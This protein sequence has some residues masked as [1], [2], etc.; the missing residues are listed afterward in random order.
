MDKGIKAEGKKESADVNTKSPRHVIAAAKNV[1]M[2]RGRA[3]ESSRAG[4]SSTLRHASAL[5]PRLSGAD[6]VDPRRRQAAV[7][8]REEV[9]T[10]P[11]RRCRDGGDQRRRARGA[12]WGRYVEEGRP[13]V[14]RRSRRWRRRGGAA[15]LGF[16]AWGRWERWC[17]GFASLG[18]NEE[19]SLSRSGS[20]GQRRGWGKWWDARTNE[21]EVEWRGEWG[22]V[23]VEE[24]LRVRGSESLEATRKTG[25][26]SEAAVSGMGATVEVVGCFSELDDPGEVFTTV[27]ECDESGAGN[28]NDNDGEGL[29]DG[30]FCLKW[31][32]GGGGALDGALKGMWCRSEAVRIEK[33][34]AGGQRHRRRR[35]SPS[36]ATRTI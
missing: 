33:S 30:I 31:S 29:Q 13:W 16:C 21:H 9:V 23:H 24:R 36:R 18:E 20:C 27:L 4:S 28:T 25:R 10:F 15:R 14:Q 2:D 3:A 26:G 8:V 11:R 5:P 19:R 32:E 7:D 35:L 22:A 17:R 34:R 1:E 6:A 12:Q